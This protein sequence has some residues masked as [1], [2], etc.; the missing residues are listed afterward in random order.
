MWACALMSASRRL[1]LPIAV[2]LFQQLFQI[3]LFVVYNAVSNRLHLIADILSS[4]GKFLAWLLLHLTNDDRS[5]DQGLYV[6][7]EQALGMP[8]DSVIGCQ[9]LIMRVVNACLDELG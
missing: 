4:C 6:A 7:M 3:W 2:E 8:K 5:D 1:G 9:F